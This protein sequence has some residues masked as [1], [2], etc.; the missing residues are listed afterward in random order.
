MMQAVLSLV[1]ESYFPKGSN[2]LLVHTGG[3]L[4]LLSRYD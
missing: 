2:I 3:L 1:D 4:G